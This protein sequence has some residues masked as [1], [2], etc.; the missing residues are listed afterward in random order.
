MLTSNL[1][2]ETPVRFSL[3]WNNKFYATYNFV[4]Y[5]L[6]QNWAIVI[7]VQACD[8]ENFQTV[9]LLVVYLPGFAISN[10]NQ[11]IKVGKFGQQSFESK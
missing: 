10:T 7:K 6:K 8:C 4:E 2:C 3:D 9:V 1:I 11:K 5:T